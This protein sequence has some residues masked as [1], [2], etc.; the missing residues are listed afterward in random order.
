[1]AV[2]PLDHDVGE[3]AQRR[4]VPDP[5]DE[6]HPAAGPDPEDPA[7]EGPGARRHTPILAGAGAADRLGP[8]EHPST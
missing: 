7:G 8:W 6:P 3:R 4:G 1:M 2:G 5:D